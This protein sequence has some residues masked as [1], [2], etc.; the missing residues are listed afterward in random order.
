M[1]LPYHDGCH[2]TLEGYHE[3][4]DQLFNLVNRDFYRSTDTIGINS[5]NM[6]KAF[7]ANP[8]RD[9]IGLLFETHGAD[10]LIPNDTIVSSIHAS[11]RDYLYVGNDTGTASNLIVSKDTLWLKLSKPAD[12]NYISYLPDKNYNHTETTYE[13]PWLTNSRGLGAFSF[14]HIPILDSINANPLF[15]DSSKNSS[16]DDF[17]LYPNPSYSSVTIQFFV[18]KQTHVRITLFDEAG[19][20]IIRPVDE[21]REAGTYSIG[22]DTRQFG[23]TCAT[24][25][26]E[27]D[28]SIFD[29]QLIIVH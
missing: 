25:R 2:F 10:I 20:K 14:W 3:L 23:A 12:T 6:T 8:E 26:L 11:I 17:Q 18:D 13:G 4:G 7:F 1:A 19:R 27:L 22:L 15:I 21:V 28:E 16:S 9:V 29:K 5:P 24:V